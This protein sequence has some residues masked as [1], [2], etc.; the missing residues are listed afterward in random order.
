MIIFCLKKTY[1][2]KNK[3]ELLSPVL[4]PNDLREMNK[5]KLIKLLSKLNSDFM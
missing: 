4:E 2:N 1:C 5:Y 3:N